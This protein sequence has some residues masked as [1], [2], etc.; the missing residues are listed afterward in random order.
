MSLFLSTRNCVRR[1]ALLLPLA[2]GLLSLLT[3]SAAMAINVGYQRS[4]GGVTIRPDGV[5]RQLDV[6]DQAE[7]VKHFRANLKPVPAGLNLPVE[8]R[9]ISLRGI[10]AALREVQ[11]NNKQQ[12]PDEV[13]YLAGIQRVQW[14]F[15]DPEKQDI[16]LAGPGEG[17]KVN[18]QGNVVGVTTGRPVILLEDLLVALRSTDSARSG[19]GISVSIEP[20][21]EGR[22]SFEQFIGRFHT[23]NPQVIAGA[24][25]AMG[26]QRIILTGVPETSHFARV[27]VASDYHMKC[28]A[29][30]LTESGV[31]GLPSYLDLLK[32][33]RQKPTS[34]TP[35]WWMA[36]NYDPLARSADKLA[37]QLRGPGVKVM[38]ENDFV[39][40]DGTVR[41]TGKQDPVARDWA[42][43]MTKTYDELS[44]KNP[45]FGELRNL[46]DLCVVS[47][48]IK[49]EGLTNLAGCQLPTLFANQC[50]AA[51][52]ELNAAKTTATQCSFLR[53]GNNFVI[54]ASGGVDIDSWAVAAKSE[55]DEQVKE[56]RAK[57]V[58]PAR[59][60]WWWN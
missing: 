5:L 3:A 55:V 18:E 24:S 58:A 17:W 44:R 34:S 26:P 57:A 35:R 42:E 36:C 37:W 45:V 30:K 41:G 59:A 54:T 6:R 27:L 43:R 12:L 9:K 39:A 16:V 32:Q 56:T 53:I 7:I 2:A 28:M 13:K 49:K 38:T 15:V 10:D 29:M 11:M 50:Q 23:F 21:P 4:V 20:T 47:A 25:E 46:M 31:A 19:E 52:D 8:I 33:K 22:R 51:C 60:S 1:Q 14:I 48:I 40:A